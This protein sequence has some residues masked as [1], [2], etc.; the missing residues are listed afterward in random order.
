MSVKQQLAEAVA[1][2]P[3]SVSMEEAFARL[4]RAFQA[5]QERLAADAEPPP[6]RKVIE[7][8]LRRLAAAAGTFVGPVLSAEALRREAM[9]EDGT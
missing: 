4:Y 2:L 5:K 1:A 8:R 7:E 9:Y 3:E 6:P